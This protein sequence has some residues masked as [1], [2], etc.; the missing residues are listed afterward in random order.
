MPTAGLS[1]V[2]GLLGR[3]LLTLGPLTP[4]PNEATV[5]CPSTSLLPPPEPREWMYTHGQ[6]G[7][8]PLPS[9]PR[10]TSGGPWLGDPRTSSKKLTSGAWVRDAPGRGAGRSCP[11]GTG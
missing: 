8:T 10:S 6:A 4:S 5:L 7:R 2:L 1:C 9:G 11:G 3:Q